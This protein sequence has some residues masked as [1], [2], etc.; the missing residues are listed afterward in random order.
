[1]YV[2]MCVQ[3]RLLFAVVSRCCTRKVWTQ[4]CLSLNENTCYSTFLYKNVVLLEVYADYAYNY[5]VDHFC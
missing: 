1:M 4:I 2:R 3:Y 5:T